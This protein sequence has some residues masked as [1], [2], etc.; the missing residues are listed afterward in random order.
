VPTRTGHQRSSTGAGPS[1]RE[2][3][4]PV[5]WTGLLAVRDGFVVIPDHI[6]PTNPRRVYD[7]DDRAER[8]Y[9]Y[10]VVLADGT[11]TDINQLI[12]RTALLEL[13][14]DLYLSQAVRS[15][16]ADTITALR[17]PG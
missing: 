15:A 10:E 8:K 1:R 17:H 13:W 2:I 3:G 16:W 14:N 5:D 11:S 9:L 6:D 12:A 7:L 4:P